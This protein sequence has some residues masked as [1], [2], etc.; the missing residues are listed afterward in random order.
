M[1]DRLIELMHKQFTELYKDGDWNFVEMIG[2]VADYLLENGVIVPPCEVGD[3]VYVNPKT[4]GGISFVNYDNLFIHSKYFLIAEVVSVIKTRKQN[5]IKLKVY[6][7]TTYT[8]EYR[9]YPVSSIG[10]TV[11]L[12][13][14]EAEQ[15]LKGGEG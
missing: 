1:R 3:V 7:R 5:L 11:F 4:W 9:R 2:G 10:K 14:E 8:P 6:N 15:A 12:T 13:R